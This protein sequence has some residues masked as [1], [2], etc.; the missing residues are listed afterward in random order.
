MAIRDSATWASSSLG[1]L[2]AIAHEVGLRLELGETFGGD[3]GHP[4]LIDVCILGVSEGPG[5]L[6]LPS[7]PRDTWG[8]PDSLSPWV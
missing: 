2:V 1:N 7:E 6:S 5:R 8:E 4:T 3:H